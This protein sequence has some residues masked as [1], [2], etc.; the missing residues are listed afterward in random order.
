MTSAPRLVVFVLF[1]PLARRFGLACW[2]P[3]RTVSTTAAVLLCSLPD[4][5]HSCARLRIVQARAAVSTIS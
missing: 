4:G 5:R 1:F 3:P 2:V